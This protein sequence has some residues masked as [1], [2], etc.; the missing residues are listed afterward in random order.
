MTD[1]PK[2]IGT[3]NKDGRFY[4][5]FDKNPSFFTLFSKFLLNCGFQDLDVYEDYLDNPPDIN[6]IKNKLE[7]IRND[8]YDIDIIYTQDRIILIIRTN[9]I[10]KDNLDI[11]ITK[12]SA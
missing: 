10:N 2:L 11:G 12:M 5:I 7:H 8:K 4:Y 9:N 1:K 3:G 6:K